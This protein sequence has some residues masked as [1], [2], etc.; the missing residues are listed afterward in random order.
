MSRKRLRDPATID[1]ELVEI[2]EDLANEREDIRL[3]AARSLLSKV[4]PEKSP[5]R[6]RLVEILTRL[7][8]GLCSARKAARVGF[9][10]ALTE[11]LVQLQGN[12]VDDRVSHLDIRE[13]LEI[14]QKQTVTV[15]DNTGTVSRF[16]SYDL[17]VL[18][19]LQ[20]AKN[21]DYGR[22]FGAEAVFKSGA[23][24]RSVDSTDCWKRILDF[25]LELAKKRTWLRRDCGWILFSSIDLSNKNADYIQLL[26]EKIQRSGLSKTP[27]GIAVWLKAQSTG[28]RLRFPEKI[29]HKDDP[30][31]RREKT[32]LANVL[33]E[34]T[35][36]QRDQQNDTD[37]A[38]QM[39]NWSP[40]LHFAWDVV[41]A[42]LLDQRDVAHP[43]NKKQGHR[44]AFE[45]FWKEAVDGIDF[46]M[47]IVLLLTCIRSPII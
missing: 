10:V 16:F 23:L 22:L 35:P 40:N 27:E 37:R 17:P 30:L 4:S 5:T 34:T 8:R 19:S 31:H 20:E 29:W 38:N 25:I 12:G 45:E 47:C 39:G 3:K 14:L 28:L 13:V 21:Y 1:T 44:I 7:V 2:Y 9:S 32:I 33:K 43:K 41:I 46:N 18:M 24:F 15:G 42:T 36:A 26:L 6:E 11:F